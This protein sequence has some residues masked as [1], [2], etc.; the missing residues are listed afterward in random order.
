MLTNDQLLKLLD[1]SPTVIYLAD[2][3]PDYAAHYVSNALKT[4]LGYE[5][6]EFTQSPGFWASQIHPDD[7]PR[8][9]RELER[10]S[11]GKPNVIEY[12]FR[13][14]DGSWRWMRD[15][16]KLITDDEGNP[17]EIIGS[18]IDVTTLKSAEEALLDAR[19][20]FQTI[21]EQSIQGV[22]IHRNWK[23]IYANAAYAEMLG[24]E[25]PEE[26]I[27][28]GSM[29]KIY[30]SK[31]H[32]RLRGFQRARM[33]GGEAPATYEFDAIRKDGLL[34]SLQSFVR[35]ITWEG[36]DATLHTSIDIT[37]RKLAETAMRDSE[38]QLRLVT[39]NIPVA[40]IDSRYHL[41]FINSTAA[42]WHKCVSTELAGK[43]VSQVMDETV[44][45]E[46][47]PHMEAAL[48]GVRQNFEHRR[49][50]ADGKTRYINIIYV[51][52]FLP[53]GQVAG[54]FA[55]GA[56]VTERRRNQE[57]VEESRR[58]LRRLLRR[59]RDIR[60]EER[61]QIGLE[62]HDELTQKLTALKLI[63]SNMSMHDA[64][65][66]CDHPSAQVRLSQI[67]DELY[68]SLT[69]LSM[70]MR[71]APLELLGL[72]DAIRSQLESICRPAKLK[73]RLHMAIGQ[74]HLGKE[75]ELA[76]YRIVQEALTNVIRHA[77]ASR[78]DISVE[79][80]FRGILTEVIDNGIG[81]ARRNIESERG[82]GIIGMRERAIALGGTVRIVRWRPQGTAVRLWLPNNNRTGN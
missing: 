9:F 30:A 47:R 2:A 75:T 28:L 59:I 20:R 39:E 52:H 35:R 32:E 44:F 58:N 29:N 46:L 26:V 49:T 67:V 5:P 48:G 15:D 64:P 40:I 7:R 18:W 68:D 71:P 31:E 19:R 74:N 14:A 25:S 1:D 53:A 82:I 70:R 76:I 62:I 45:R 79:N 12:R 16:Q 23:P 24:Y 34:I 4:Q 27:A 65:V 72:Q 55:L 38:E 57:R 56:D 66:E 73:Y 51:P 50:F 8:V 3:Q 60:E 10:L 42:T 63:M 6:A 21:V 17:S 41:K 61:R 81:I 11:E 33:E 78:V 80:R 36:G 54:F 22:V 37:S 13:H 69:S 77:R 43:L